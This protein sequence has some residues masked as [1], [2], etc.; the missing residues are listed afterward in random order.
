M[1]FCLFWFFDT[2]VNAIKSQTFQFQLPII[3]EISQ[4][5]FVTFQD[6][7][8]LAYSPYSITLYIIYGGEHS[9]A[10]YGIISRMLIHLFPVLELQ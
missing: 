8:L 5:S 6:K 2:K 3:K 4:L 1:C 10:V 7:A 9:I